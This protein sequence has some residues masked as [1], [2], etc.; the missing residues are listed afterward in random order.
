MVPSRTTAANWQRIC[1]RDRFMMVTSDYEHRLAHRP[2]DL[3][4]RTLW[5]WA[6]QC[7]DLCQCFRST[8]NPL[9]RSN[10]PFSERATAI[11]DMGTVNRR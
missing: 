3:G 2:G 10:S 6:T 7:I 9:S 5:Q 8:H 4:K 11:T 1:S